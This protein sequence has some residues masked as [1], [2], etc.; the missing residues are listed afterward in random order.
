MSPA[1]NLARL[2]RVRSVF[3]PAPLNRP[4]FRMPSSQYL[5]R[6]AYS[7]ASRT[8]PEPDWPLSAQGREQAD[9]L[10]PI[11]QPLSIDRVVT[12]P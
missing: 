10:V 3:C 9:A 12:S 2:H 4:Q 7:V 11:L 1:I 5:L 6:H 8:V